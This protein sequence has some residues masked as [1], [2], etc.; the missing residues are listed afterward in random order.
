MPTQST[1]S[2]MQCLATGP[3]IGY[4]MTKKNVWS[5]LR[6]SAGIS[7]AISFY[8]ARYYLTEELHLSFLQPYFPSFKDTISFSLGM[9]S[10]SSIVCGF[11]RFCI[12]QSYAIKG[13]HCP[14]I[15]LLKTAD[16]TKMRASQTKY[17]PFKN[18]KLRFLCAEY[19]YWKCLS[20]LLPFTDSLESVS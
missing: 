18:V 11:F 5:Q 15:C 7:P 14:L 1:A 10:S 12:P 6:V 8:D 17:F 3:L 19:F 20:N 16:F 4:R 9:I 2:T 13:F